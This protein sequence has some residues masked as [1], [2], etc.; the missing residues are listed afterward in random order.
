MGAGHGQSKKSF[1]LSP[2]QP[3]GRGFHLPDKTSLWEGARGAQGG[4]GGALPFP[5][6]LAV[7]RHSPMWV[8]VSWA[9]QSWAGGVCA[10]GSPRSGEAHRA[11]CPDAPQQRGQRKGGRPWHG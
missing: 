3:T 7:P 1:L 5:Q 6:P 4:H 9:C 11:R 10:P 2:Q 8:L